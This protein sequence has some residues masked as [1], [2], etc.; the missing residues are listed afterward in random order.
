MGYYTRHELTIISGDNSIDHEK[1]ISE[2]T[3]YDNCFDHEIKWYE[4][5]KDMKAYSLKYPNT[6]FCLEGEGEESGDVWKKYFKNGK[7]LYAKA[8]MIFEEFDESKLR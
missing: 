7:S 6:V 1:Q 4:H 8:K 2:T 5:E 3:N